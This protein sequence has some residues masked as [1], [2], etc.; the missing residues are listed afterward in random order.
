MP[1]FLHKAIFTSKLETLLT[2][3]SD[4]FYLLIPYFFSFELIRILGPPLH[5]TRLKTNFIFF[6]R[7]SRTKKERLPPGLIKCLFFHYYTPMKLW[8]GNVFSCVCLSLSLFMGGGRGGP[9]TGP[10]PGSPNKAA[11]LPPTIQD[12]VNSGHVHTCSLWSLCCQQKAG[13]GWHWTEI[14]SQWRVQDFHETGAPTLGGGAPTCDFVKFSPKLHEIERIWTLEGGGCLKFYYVF[15]PL[16][17]YV[18]F[19]WRLHAGWAD[20]FQRQRVV[21]VQPEHVRHSRGR[22]VILQFDTLLYPSKCIADPTG[23][24]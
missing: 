14:P 4:L 18:C 8:E 2:F 12:P 19:R 7:M 16:L 5:L 20:C 21:T 22:V 10:W 13:C 17:V 23:C 6:P 1:V 11:A 9:C 3:I 24:P 15:P